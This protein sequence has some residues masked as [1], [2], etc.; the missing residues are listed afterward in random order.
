MRKSLKVFFLVLVLA[1][2]LVA[3]YTSDVSEETER[4]VK[5]A[6]VQ[7]AD[8]EASTAVASAVLEDMGYEVK[9]DVV[10]AGVMWTAVVNGD[11]DAFVCGW[12]PYTHAPY[13]KRYKD[14]VVDLGAYYK[15]AR[16]GL[17][18]PKYV[19]IESIEELKDRRSEFDGKIIGIEPGSGIMIHTREDAMPGYDLEDWELVESSGPAMT[20]QLDRVINR[21]EWIVITGWKPHWMFFKYDLKFLKDPKKAY[22][23]SEELHAIARKGLKKDMPKVAKV[24]SNFYMTDEQLGEVMYEIN[25]KHIRPKEAAR[26]WVDEHPDVVKKWTS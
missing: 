18:V 25:V 1:A 11:A 24:L 26:K 16:I 15:G 12:L 23:E 2:I 5:L 22:G 4:G 8:A 14:D 7:W 17:V 9:E 13:W 10:S 20:A 6:Y 19:P 3:A 21:K